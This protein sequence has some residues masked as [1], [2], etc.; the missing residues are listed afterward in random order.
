MK[1]SKAWSVDFLKL[2]KKNVILKS[3]V[4]V[5]FWLFSEIPLYLWTGKFSWAMPCETP[6]FWKIL[7]CAWFLLIDELFNEFFAGIFWTF[8]GHVRIGDF[9]MNGFEVNLCVFRRIFSG[10][11]KFDFFKNFL[12]YLL[13]ITHGKFYVVSGNVVFHMLIF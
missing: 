7:S 11:S 6:F 5:G 9:E 3:W 10:R 12:I 1:T 2:E 8:F 13:M 4:S